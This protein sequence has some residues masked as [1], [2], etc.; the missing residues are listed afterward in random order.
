MK[1]NYFL[2]LLYCGYSHKHEVIQEYAIANV[3]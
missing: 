3:E 2:H 1:K